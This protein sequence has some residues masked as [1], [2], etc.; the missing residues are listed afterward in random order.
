MER[1]LIG[2]G[3]RRIAAGWVGDLSLGGRAARACVRRRC[4]QAAQQPSDRQMRADRPQA[5][6]YWLLPGA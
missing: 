4:W 3:W 1:F 6:R 2:T 5:I